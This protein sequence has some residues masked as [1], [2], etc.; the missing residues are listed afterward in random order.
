[1]D[2]CDDT[3]DIVAEAWAEHRARKHRVRVLVLASALA[4]L[5]ATFAACAAALHPVID[6]RCS[7]ADGLTLGAL[8]SALLFLAV[9]VV[10]CAE[11]M[12]GVEGVDLMEDDGAT[13][14]AVML[15]I[16][17]KKEERRRASPGFPELGDD[18]G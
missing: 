15:A 3:D 17:A 8:T 6:C 12:R 13:R 9:A 1:M 14:R 10:T 16:L 2:A 7:L 11:C 18:E 5:A 4:M